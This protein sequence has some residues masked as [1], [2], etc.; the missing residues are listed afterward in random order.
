MSFHKH[1]H[2]GSKGMDLSTSSH[3]QLDLFFSKVEISRGALEVQF[4]LVQMD[5]EIK[6]ERGECQHFGG[7]IIGIYMCGQ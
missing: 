1:T 6:L 7:G 4:S 2:G 5:A 3:G